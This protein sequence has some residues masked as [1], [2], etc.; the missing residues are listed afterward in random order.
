MSTVRNS[1]LV[2]SPDAWLLQ[3]GLAAITQRRATLSHKDMRHYHQLP[4]YFRAVSL[5]SLNSSDRKTCSSV[6]CWSAL[7]CSLHTQ[8]RATLSHKDVQHYHQLPGYFGAVSLRSLNSSLIGKRAV[9]WTVGLHHSAVF[10]HKDV[11]HC[12]TKTCDIITSCLA[13]SERSRCD[14]STLH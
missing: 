14:Q 8:R 4:G 1:A 2:Q 3:S 6:D 13:T 11:R 9:V 10:T 5:R 12:H 7:L